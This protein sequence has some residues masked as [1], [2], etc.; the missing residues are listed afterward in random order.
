MLD[1]L[2]RRIIDP[3]LNRAGRLLAALRVP[4]NGAT[5]VGLSL[6]IGTIPVLAHGWYAW[7]LLLIVVNRLLDGLDGA[8]ARHVGPTAFGG[9]LDIVCD[10][11]FYAAVPLGFA[12]TGPSNAIW[13]ALLLATFI[14]TMT[15]FLGRAILAANRGEPIESTRG[16]KSFFYSAGIVEGT[17]TILVFVLFCLFPAAFPTLAG[18]MSAL[19]LWT[20]VAR[21]HEG[22]H[23][24]TAPVAPEL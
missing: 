20:V 2:M 10:S 8:I 1:P 3:P 19:C 22:S 11:V 13:A 9:Y 21:L 12:L 24:A 16:R 5:L 15:S 4:P 6:A 7:G 23:T 17:E 18:V 14:C